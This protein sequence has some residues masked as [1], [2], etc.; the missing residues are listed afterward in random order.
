MLAD[1][2]EEETER[3]K[4]LRL[5]V[6]IRAKQAKRTNLGTPG[7]TYLT[8]KRFPPNELAGTGN[9]MGTFVYFGLHFLLRRRLCCRAQDMAL[10]PP[11]SGD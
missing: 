8:G 7:Q 10:F 9:P 6:A 3:R 1:F 2:S 4:T 11:D 5:F